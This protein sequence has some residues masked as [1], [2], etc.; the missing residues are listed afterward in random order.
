M[1]IVTKGKALKVSSSIKLVSVIVKFLVTCECVNFVK[2]EILLIQISY[3]YL[4]Y[5]NTN[6]QIVYNSKL[7]VTIDTNHDINKTKECIPLENVPQPLLRAMHVRLFSF[8]NSPDTEH[9]PDSK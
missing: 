8:I 1:Q 6:W 4:L 3:P 9:S 5:F 2:V 7:N